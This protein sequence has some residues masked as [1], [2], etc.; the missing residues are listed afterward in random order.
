M[1]RHPATQPSLRVVGQASLPPKDLLNCRSIPQSKPAEGTLRHPRPAE[2]AINLDNHL[3]HS[4]ILARNR[5]KERRTA[6]AKSSL[7]SALGLAGAWA[8]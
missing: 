6:L 5:S 3:R 8:M 1:L 4:S 7:S 2:K